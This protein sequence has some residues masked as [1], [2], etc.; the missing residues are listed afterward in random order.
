[1]K[2]F[3]HNLY[4][5][6]KE[7][8][9]IMGNPNNYYLPMLQDVARVCAME[10]SMSKSAQW[11]KETSMEKLEEYILEKQKEMDTKLFFYLVGIA[12]AN[13]FHEVDKMGNNDALN[14]CVGAMA[15]MEYFLGIREDND[16]VDNGVMLD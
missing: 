10:E 11:A 9:R 4:E 1:M 8:S 6:K 7:R 15:E 13:V 5:K 12:V 2:V 3:L 14:A 16:T